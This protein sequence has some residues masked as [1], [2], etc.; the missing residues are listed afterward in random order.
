VR[1]P[2]K[3][4]L[5]T[6]AGSGIGRARALAFAREGAAVVAAD[7][8]EGAAERVARDIVAAAAVFLASDESRFVLG[9]GLIIDG[10]MTACRW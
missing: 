1:L 8:N 7:V 2:D 6:E 9:A 10:G 3:I 5:I 4:C